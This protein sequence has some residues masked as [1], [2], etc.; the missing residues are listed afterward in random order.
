MNKTLLLVICDFLL[1]NL[2]AL[3]H[4]EK[5]EPPRV[6]AAA[7]AQKSHASEPS[8]NADMVELM[9][10][11]LEDEKASREQLAAKLNATQGTLSEKEKSVA[12]LA[13]QKTQ[14]EG[15]L[16]TST[17]NAKEL[18][19]KYSEATNEAF[20]TKE[21]LA[22][23]QRDLEERRAEAAR[24][25]QQIS[26]MERQNTEARQRIE[27]LN[28]A[29]GVAEQEKQLLNQNL[30]EAKQQ[31]EV[32]R[33]ERA[34]VQEQTTQL[35]QAVSQQAVKSGEL[36]QEI[37]DTKPVNPNSIFSDFLANRVTT[38][39]TT[40]RPGLFSPTVKDRETQTILVTDGQHTYA[41]MHVNDTPFFLSFENP[42]DYD[43]ISG[44]LTRG[45]FNAPIKELRFL[46][47]DPRIVI[48][49]IDDML[50][51]SMG[52][53]IYRLATDIF[54]A[55]D[56]LLVRADDGK[57]G[58][59]PFRIDTAMPGYI[60]VD[61]RV[62]TRLFGDFAPKSGDLMFSKQGDL[63]GI[64]VNNDYCAVL[65]DFRASQVLKTGDDVSQGHTGPVFADIAARWQRLPA[66][67]Q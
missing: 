62:V 28:V 48:A 53:K 5:A 42:P 2:L 41:L 55:S 21:Q 54:K 56:A 13:Q 46:A 22:K 23:L 6:Q 63:I 25:A 12:Q 66:K 26:E 31:I 51:A 40:R 45:S 39:I 52:A 17:S 15:S 10:V 36:T 37:R 14:L 67:L 30:T 64:M 19:K 43:Q 11:S 35:T 3:T 61:N 9:K 59:T 58:E 27:K 34:K 38:K 47:A 49:P 29:V 57:Y 65:A 18:E 24:Q 32:E 33:T 44:K 60:K 20:L 50:A 1:L 8:I 7:V 16:A 4:W